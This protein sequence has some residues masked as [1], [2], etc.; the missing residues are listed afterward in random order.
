MLGKGQGA[1]VPASR[2]G[3]EASTSAMLTRARGRTQRGFGVFL[4]AGGVLGATLS[5]VLAPGVLGVTLAVAVGLLGAGL[6]AAWVRRGARTMGLA[7]ADEGRA[8]EM[9]IYELAKQRGGRLTADET[10]AGLKISF[11][12]ADDLLT[13][14]VG[15]GSRID[16]DVDDEGVVTFV[17]RELASA[18]PRVRVETEAEPRE[19]VEE[20]VQDDRAPAHREA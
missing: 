19:E 4:L 9:A 6:G 10:A 8:T 20:E 1:I 7:R 11:G 5:M 12:V 3:R 17:F 2:T 14:L 18:S 15:D 13:R 16:V